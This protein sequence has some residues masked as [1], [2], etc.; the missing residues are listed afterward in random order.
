MK[1]GVTHRSRAVLLAA[2][3]SGAATLAACGGTGTAGASDK[4]LN[5]YNWAGYIAPNTVANF[6]RET[7]ITVH[8]STYESNEISE[9][10]LL[11][12]RSNYDVVTSA[13][14]FFERQLHAGVFRKLDKAALS[15]SG[16]LD[17]E[18]LRELAVHDP[19]NLYAV[20]YLWTQA[21]LGY[22]VDKVRERLGSAEP[23][24]W[25]LLFDP[26]FASKL[27]DC[28]IMIVDSPEDVLP[29]VL[30]YLGKDPNSHDPA[31]WTAAADVLM[32]IR[33]FVRSIEAEGIIAD[34]A[35]G[36]L[37][38]GLT[39][40]G[41][42]TQARYRALEAGNGVRIRYFVP[43]EGAVAG[44]D[45]LAIPADAPHP[46]NAH[47]WLNYLMRPEVM[48]DISNALKYPNGNKASLAFVQDAIK[49]DAAIY[50]DAETRAKLAIE[51]MQP[52]ELKRLMTR[53]WTRF[54]TG[55]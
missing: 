53:L 26:K 45:M 13:D 48:A 25:S 36:S 2:L 30:I 12:G 8:Y 41:E 47:K 23:D 21:G 51:T 17:P 28:G 7:G 4:S 52:P 44:L 1:P 11:T 50:P 10:K 38:L 42:V 9:T 54:R 15:N 6:E 29:S 24:S 35:N 16:N 39:W 20:P 19:G 40:G 14:A 33:P 5:V 37:C 31:D 18:L 22:N 43:R 27:K 46:E 34:L 49:N 32:Q 55:Q 3:L